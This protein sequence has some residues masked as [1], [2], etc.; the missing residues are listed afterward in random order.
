MEQYWV[1][2]A[3]QVSDSSILTHNTEQ[4]SCK[5]PEIVSASGKCGVSSLGKELMVAAPRT[6]CGPALK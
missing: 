4:E 6:A 5:L 2:V 1:Q 3:L